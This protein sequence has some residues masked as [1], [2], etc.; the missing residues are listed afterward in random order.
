MK[1]KRSDIIFTTALVLLGILLSI[2]VYLPRSSSGAYLEVRVDGSV[3]QTWPLSE[4]RTETIQTTRGTNTFYIKNKV[5]YMS[6][7]DCS[8]KVCVKMRGISKTGETIV[9]LPHKLV[10][11]IVTSS[12]E[13]ELDAVTGGAP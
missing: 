1:L 11:E 9:C 7:A 13:A 5:V 2:L 3:L 12:R 8:D 4:N 10:L 6:D